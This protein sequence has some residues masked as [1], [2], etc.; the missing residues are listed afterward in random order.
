MHFDLDCIVTLNDLALRFT[1]L[2]GRKDG[3]TKLPLLNEGLFLLLFLFEQRPFV[4]E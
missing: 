1:A 4:T 2:D 3:R